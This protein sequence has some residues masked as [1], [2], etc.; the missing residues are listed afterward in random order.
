MSGTCYASEWMNQ[1]D[2]TCEVFLPIE[3]VGA[4]YAFF[5]TAFLIAFIVR[6]GLN[7]CWPNRPAWI[8]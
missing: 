6:H 4:F 2:P 1:V 3:I 7:K 8:S 5:G